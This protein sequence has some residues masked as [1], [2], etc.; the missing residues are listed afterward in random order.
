M[1]SKEK[2]EAL[3]AKWEEELKAY[4]E[5]VDL[6]GTLVGDAFTIDLMEQTI[7]DLKGLLE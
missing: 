7:T 6:W 1:I 2:V 3:I 4:L 5:Q